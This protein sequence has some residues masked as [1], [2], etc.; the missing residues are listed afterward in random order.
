MQRYESIEKGIKEQNVESLRESIGSICYT[1]RDFSDGEFDAVV[2]YV[3]SCG[4]DL[5]ESSLVGELI[6][7]SKDI[8]TDEDFARAVFEL[9]RNFCK[10]RIEDVK[11]IGIALYKKEPAEEPF[12]SEEAGVDPNANC[13]QTV[14]R[15]FK[16]AGLVVAGMAV[17][18]LAI[19]VVVLLL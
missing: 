19:T 18:A 3:L 10:E 11:K 5:Y 1:C 2:A 13:H 14:N 12:A 7:Q 4:I 6:S 8:F 15:K 17:L 16:I 9:K